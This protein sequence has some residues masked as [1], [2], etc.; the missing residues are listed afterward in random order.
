MDLRAMTWRSLGG[1]CTRVRSG[2]SSMG[3]LKSNY[4]VWEAAHLSSEI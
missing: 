3:D 4:G 1:A 2:E